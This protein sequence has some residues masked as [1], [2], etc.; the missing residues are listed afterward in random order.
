MRIKDKKKVALVLSG[1]GIKAAAFHIGVCL[2]LQEKGFK[3]AGG[4]KEMVRQ[5]TNEDDPMTI[6]CYVGSS[7]GAFVASILGAGYPVESLINAFQIGSGTNPSFDKSD[8][9]YLKPISYRD[10][11][12]LNS[13]GLLKF[14]PRT[15]L[16]KTLVSG[17]IE[18]LL[19]NGLKLN[20]LFSTRGIESYL[21]KEVLID[22]DFAR[23]GVELFIVGTQLNHSRK[24]IFGNFHESFKTSNT[25]YINYSTISEAV[26]ASTSL[27]PVFAPYG[28][29]RP[30]G[31]EIFYYDGEIRDT[32]STHVAADNGADLVISSYSI[33]PYHYTEEMGSLHKYG[34][35]LILNQALYQVVQQKIA[36]HIQNQTDIKNIYNAVDGYLKQADVPNEHREKLLQIIREKVNHRPE[37]DYIY[38]APRPQNYEMFFVDHFSLNPEI[39]ARIVRI[40]FK[41]AINILRQHDI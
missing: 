16:D 35:P 6:R 17:G 28:I 15:L 30:D 21:R 39:L 33:Q 19:K 31:K 5:N 4:T 13:S 22:N 1:G 38:I 23:L 14:I 27:P 41:S 20:G 18:S 12:N 29:K 9:R 8:L 11:F 36:K 3:F 32:L 2:A 40:G 10:I 24:A 7:A 25:K 37:V 34:I 26:A